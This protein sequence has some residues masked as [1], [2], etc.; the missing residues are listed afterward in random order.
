MRETV[1]FF[2]ADV[3]PNRQ[4]ARCC[5]PALL[6]PRLKEL[7]IQGCILGM[8]QCRMLGS[9]LGHPE[10]MLERL[11][12]SSNVRLHDE[13]FVARALLKNTRLRMLGL[14]E[15]RKNRLCVLAALAAGSQLTEVKLAFRGRLLDCVE[16]VQLET[17]LARCT[18]TR[19]HL[20]DVQLP[21]ESLSRGLNACNSLKSL[22]LV[23]FESYPMLRA[24][25]AER[26]ESYDEDMIAALVAPFKKV[27]C[28]RLSFVSMPDSTI[29]L[30]L[31]GN[32]TL[33]DFDLAYNA[34]DV[35]PLF[36]PAIA[37]CVN[38]RLLVIDSAWES[39]E[40]LQ[41]LVLAVQNLSQL[42]SLDIGT[43]LDVI[44]DDEP[45]EGTW[46]AEGGAGWL[47]VSLAR[48]RSVQHLDVCGL[49]MS[50]AT[51]G[52]L[53]ETLSRNGPLESL[54]FESNDTEATVRRLGSALWSRNSHL[55]CVE[56]MGDGKEA[57]QMLV[58]RNAEMQTRCRRAV[59]TFVAIRKYRHREAGW[60][61]VPPQVVQ[62]MAKYLWWTRFEWCWDTDPL[63]YNPYV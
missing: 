46:P 53:C 11:R 58:Q 36:L 44:D 43:C 6:L 28:V 48:L 59:M 39:V 24:L 13:G 2:V 23:N 15:D 54:A 17:A 21:M 41:A 42:R 4:A 14:R 1:V 50:S 25:E 33:T 34:E 49:I 57:F 61:Y 52:L 32:T 40:M 35:V 18:L 7:H 55:T 62:E 56:L 26:E 5:F 22:E 20:S 60:A 30:L 51:V 12:L 31:T 45:E 3:S 37:D 10:C 38:L 9:F 63:P 19:L 16:E 27:P 8:K 29:R 47:V